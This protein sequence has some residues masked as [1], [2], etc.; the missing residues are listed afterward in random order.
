MGAKRD[1]GQ[2]D[3]PDLRHAYLVLAVVGLTGFQ[4][5][6]A[7]SIIFVAYPEIRQAFPDSSPVELSWVLNVFSIVGAP[8]M[9]LGSAFS[10]R[11]GRKR[12]MLLGVAGFTAASVL[13]AL[14]P[15]PIWIIGA[16]GLMALAA[17]LIL[18][19]SAALILREFPA[20]H[21]GIAMGTWSAAGG[22]AGALGPSLGGWL[23]DNG[24]WQWA[25]WINVPIGIL[26]L[27]AGAVVL[28][29]SRED[30]R[31]PLPDAFG[32]LLLMVGVGTLVFGLVQ[33]REWGWG[34]PREL[35]ALVIGTSLIAALIVRSRRHP[36]PILRLELFAITPY[37]LGNA[38]MLFFSLS[39]FG[40]QF[41]SLQLLTG[42]WGYDLT[43]AGL[44][45]TP[46]FLCIAF[47]GPVS[48]R[49]SDRFGNWL[50]APC[51]L[52]WVLSL[53]VFAVLIDGE[54][55]MVLWWI[56]VVVGGMGSGFVWGALFA[57]IMKS[58]P[59]ADFSNGASVTQTLQR[60]GNAL[61]VAVMV[62]VLS[63]TLTKGS[64]ES[65]PSAFVVLA[66]LGL[67]ATIIGH[68]AS[69]ATDRAGTRPPAHE[70]V[71]TA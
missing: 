23:V 57:M 51:A 39:F 56:F 45:A 70:P 18:P 26:S 65:F 41:V 69:R 31:R 19:V 71:T 40:F 66:V 38:M 43:T 29:E 1:D 11:I 36:E 63:A 28:R 8:T 13:A 16:R 44:L 46:I 50:L 58:V 12:A 3:T 20:S 24:G 17:S 53:A 30:E 60:I 22:I 7:L 47:M 64:I 59:P 33:T 48:G 35:A 68:G 34:D 14:A 15:T 49:F 6:M 52:V 32:A 67:I 21:R 42:P 27:I 2:Q 62:T 5:S 55:N 10:E 4:T 37:R 54:P 61:G 9:V 25:F